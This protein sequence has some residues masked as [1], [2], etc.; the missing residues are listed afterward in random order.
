MP[1]I[2][3]KDAYSVHSEQ[4]DEHHRHFVGIINRLYD[5][6]M[7]TDDIGSVQPIVSELVDYS[8]YHFTAEE[9]FMRETG[10]GE[11]AEHM[12]KHRYFS[13]KIGELQKM[14]RDNQLAVARELIVFLGDWLLHHILEVDKHY[15][16]VQPA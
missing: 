9:Q 8:S 13:E 12:A 5:S 4:L 1:L 10:H 11:L 14:E 16:S 2:Q 6:V 15:A 3:W 7:S